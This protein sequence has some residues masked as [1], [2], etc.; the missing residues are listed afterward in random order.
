LRSAGPVTEMIDVPLQFVVGKGGVG[1]ST[2][3]TALALEAAGRGLRT[4]LVEIGRDGGVMRLFDQQ[5]LEPGKPRIVQPNL[6]LL[7]LEG[8]EALAEYLR[9]AVPI[10]R[11]MSL[12]FAS[13]FYNIFVSGAP[14]LKELMTIGKIW[15][16]ADRKLA[17]GKP[18][19]E[20]IVVDAGASGHSL[21]YLQMPA[22]AATTFRSGLVHREA[23][24]VQER[25]ADPARSCVH[26]V[27]TPEEMPVTEACNIVAKLR[28]PLRL[29]I[30][31]LFLNR[32][33][34]E[35]PRGADEA[36][37]AL[38]RIELDPDDEPLRGAMREAAHSA[39]EWSSV[40]DAAI[41]R[42][43]RETGLVAESVPLLVREEFGLDDARELA[44]SFARLRA[45][46]PLRAKRQ[47]QAL[48]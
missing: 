9:M 10:K 7:A 46:A 13:R 17:D 32:R 14:G 27:A 35:P 11:L 29:P 38:D 48:A 20:R 44:V 36:I 18:V 1:K 12:V 47:Q 25:L 15:Y 24:R 22:A 43:E 2:I 34:P 8:D 42:L 45:Q 40:Q 23:M 28:D 39:I 3:A 19:W 21:Q 31:T 33:R 4:L 30:G 37:A 5:G 16:E 41:A 6:T 26:V